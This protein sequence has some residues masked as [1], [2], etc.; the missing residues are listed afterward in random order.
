M[1]TVNGPIGLTAGKFIKLINCLDGKNAIQDSNNPPTFISAV[2]PLASNED[3][4]MINFANICLSLPTQEKRKQFCKNSNCP[5]LSADNFEVSVSSRVNGIFNVHTV[6]PI[7]GEI[8]NS[9]SIGPND[10]EI[11]TIPYHKKFPLRIPTKEFMGHQ[12]LDI[13]KKY[14]DSLIQI[15]IKEYNNIFNKNGLILPRIIDVG[16]L[17]DHTDFKLL[18]VTGIESAIPADLLTI[19]LTGWNFLYKEP[20]IKDLTDLTF[21][22]PEEVEMRRPFFSALTENILAQVN[23]LQRFKNIKNHFDNS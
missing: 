15:L 21:S 5:L 10:E 1:D 8:L 22:K 7:N 14:S 16:F 18:K 12:V 9:R 19:S 2:C 11:N 17:K 13:E 20:L 23:P 6:S 3:P 4:E